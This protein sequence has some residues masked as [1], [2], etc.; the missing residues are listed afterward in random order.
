[1]SIT[2]SICS[3]GEWW[4]IVHHHQAYLLLRTVRSSWLME[5]AKDSL[6]PCCYYET[7]QKWALLHHNTSVQEQNLMSTLLPLLFTFSKRSLG[8]VELV[9]K[10]A[11]EDLIVFIKIAGGIT[12]NDLILSVTTKLDEK[13]IVKLWIVICVRREGPVSGRATRTQRVIYACQSA[14]KAQVHATTST[15]RKTCLWASNAL[16][17]SPTLRYSFLYV[18]LDRSLRSSRRRGSTV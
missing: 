1:M 12:K 16:S 11:F 14:S 18:K 2:F 3:T 10:F 9:G 7:P 15:H 17:L 8:A 6:D 5:D 13:L 4:K